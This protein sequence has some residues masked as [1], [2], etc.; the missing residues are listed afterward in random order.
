MLRRAIAGAALVTSLAVSAQ[1]ASI[2]DP[3]FDELFVFGDSLNDCCINPAAPFTN[4]PDTWLVEFA[5]LIGA[6]YE[7]STVYNYAT[8]GA[9]SGTDNAIAPGGV[10]A[11]DGLQSQIDRFQ[12]DAPAVDSRDMA[13]IWV[14]TNDIWASSYLG[15]T[16]FG[17]PGLDVVKP[18]GQTPGV[19]ELAGYIAG[20]IR[21]AV[22]DLRD[23]GFGNALLLT[24]YDIGDSALVDDIP[25]GPERNTAYSEAL[26]EAMQTLYTP[27]IDTYVL[28]VVELIRDLQAGAPENGFL[29]LGTFP[30]C[31][32]GDILCS[33][34][35]EAEQDTFIYFDFVHLT[36]ATNSEVARAAASLVKEG[37][38][39]APVPLPAGLWLLASALGASAVMAHRASR[40]RRRRA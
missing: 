20:N 14:G 25:A 23:A 4:G 9:Q 22:E 30:S 16:L 7:E 11:P 29:E 31:S 24:P 27:G 12:A 6:T 2:D 28:D 21:T 15:D 18:L 3:Y 8:G 35:D 1:A 40:T 33:D 37:D 17:L 13:V 10:P 36:R 39:L 19:E 38:P 34:R 32:F 5:D 26:V